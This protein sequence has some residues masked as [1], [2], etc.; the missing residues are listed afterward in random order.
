MS[1]IEARLADLGLVLPAPVQ[2][3]AGVVLPFRFVRIIGR[4]A[5]IAGHGPQNADGSI[6]QPLGK[7]G[8][9]LSIEQGYAAA[10]LTGLAILA[11]LQRAIGDLDR[12][13]AWTRV[14]GMVNS[15][16]GF[17]RQPAV[18]NGFS[19]LVIELF[20]AEIGAHP[21]SAVGLFELPFSIPVEIEAEVEFSS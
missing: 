5:F 15:A 3:P 11:S 6:A 2:A 10:K 17:V 18:I 13:A 21:R 14:F 16:P 19:E 9:D 20:G 7:V 8:S 4:R 12:I 1:R